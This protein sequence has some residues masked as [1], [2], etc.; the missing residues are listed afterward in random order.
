MYQFLAIPKNRKLA[1]IICTGLIL[2]SLLLN[3]SGISAGWTQRGIWIISLC[4]LFCC[5][6]SMT[7][8]DSFWI[9]FSA[10]LTRIVL[11]VLNIQSGNIISTLLFR[12]GDDIVFANAAR[13][14]YNGNLAYQVNSR[15]FPQFVSWCY[16]VFGLDEMIMILILVF[17]AMIGCLAFYHMLSRLT[18]SERERILALFIVCF[19]PFN[20]IFSVL[21]LREPIYFCFITLSFLFYQK[22]C[23]KYQ[24]CDLLVAI[25]L[26]FP[27]ILMHWGYVGVLIVYVSHFV[28]GYKSI[29]GKR[30]QLRIIKIT[31]LIVLLFMAATIVLNS[32]RMRYFREAGSFTD[33]LILTFTKYSGLDGG[34]KYLSDMQ[35]SSLWDIVLF[36]PIRIVYFYLSP[37]F[38]DWRG[39]KDILCFLLD[40]IFPLLMCLVYGYMRVM[41][42]KVSLET[43]TVIWIIFLTGVLFCWATVSAGAAIRHRN[44]LIPLE[45]YAIMYLFSERRTA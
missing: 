7:K 1:L 36:T 27:A 45:M 38:T 40:S 31:F 20:I 4:L 11:A 2:L 42:R 18:L 26:T 29:S 15:R 32:G 24:L 23:F 9:L 22:F 34:S 5:L 41:K 30:V 3:L 21:L 25:V 44:C 33:G 35:V 8:K 28:V 19:A 43:R 39:W 16:K 6:C 17:L 14:F 10:F 13:E 37:L 12:V